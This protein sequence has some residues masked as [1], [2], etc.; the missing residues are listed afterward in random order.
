MKRSVAV[1]LAGCLYAAH[2]AGRR[3][4]VTREEAEALL[5]GDHVVERPLWGSTRG[6]TI[7]ASPERVWPWIVQMGYPTFRAGWYTPPWLDRLTFGIRTRSSDAIRPELQSLEPGDRVPDSADW[8]AY[9]TVAAVDPPHALVLHSTRHVLPPIRSVDFSWA[10]VLRQTETRATRLL[11]RARVRY[12]PRWA[13]PF[14]EL[15]IGGGDYV[16]A[17]AMLRG[18]R[19]RVEGAPPA[20]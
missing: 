11:I 4:G 14:V 8:S 9:F 6:I 16:N 19:R 2:R 3:S 13:A 7:E 17:R 20:T 10:F 18:I 5:P 15:V 12:A 1:A